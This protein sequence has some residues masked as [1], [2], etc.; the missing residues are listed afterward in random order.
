[1]PRR[2]LTTPVVVVRTAITLR[3][4]DDDDLLTAFAR[5]PPRKRSAFIKAGLRTGTLQV[6]IEGLPDDA[7][8]AGSLESFLL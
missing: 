7:D 8:L 6:N 3:E 4:G 2:K 1:M 5:V